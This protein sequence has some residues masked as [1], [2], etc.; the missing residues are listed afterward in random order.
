MTNNFSS[1]NIVLLS[2]TIVLCVIILGCAAIITYLRVKKIRSRKQAKEVVE[3][4]RYEPLNKEVARYRRLADQYKKKL[5]DQDYLDHDKTL[6]D[7]KVILD[8]ELNDYKNQ[9]L[10]KIE[11]EIQKHKNELLRHTILSAMQPLHLKVINESSVHYLPIADKYKP[12]LIGKKGRNIKRLNEITNCNINVDKDSAY[13]EISSPN[14]LDKQIAINTIN[15][16]I[17]SEAFDL[18]AIDSVYKKETRLIQAECIET[19]KKYLTKLNIPFNGPGLCEYVGRLKYRWSFSQNVLEHCYETALICE[20]LANQLGLDPQTAKEVGFFH[21]IGK[22]I[23]YE[24]RYDHIDTGIKIAKEFGL[25]HEVV[26]GILKHHRN[27]C[28]DDYVLLVRCADA[29]SAARKG[30]RHVPNKNDAEIIKMV[31]AKLRKIKGII[32]FKVD[33]DDKNI[34]VIFVPVIPDKKNYLDIKFEIIRTIKKDVRLNKYYVQI[35]R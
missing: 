21:D 17:K 6:Q 19:G 8:A 11:K 33:V 4:Y 15:H 10:L 23:D 25:P 3:D 14:P 26:N 13:V 22:S 30:A 9:Q 32:S 29:W 12:L 35:G 24:R 5:I 20:A 2:I 34:K 31:E 18:V 28:N 16:L 1:S 27:N 7:L